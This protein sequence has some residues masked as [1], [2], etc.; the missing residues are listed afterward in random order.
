LKTV[1]GACERCLVKSGAPGTSHQSPVTP[2]KLRRNLNQEPSILRPNR[3]LLAIV[4]LL[5]AP[6]LFAR[7]LGKYKDWDQS[8]QGYFM[9]KPER[10]QWQAVKTED[11]AEKFVNAFLANRPATF[12]QNVADRAAQADKYLTIGKLQGSKTIR[13]KVVILLGPPQGL[14]V[15]TTTKT[16]T[17]RDSP[18]A[19]DAISNV[20]SGVDSGG[21]SEGTT[22]LGSSIGTVSTSRLYHFT[23]S[24]DA[25]K[26]V[27]R[28]K[29]E[30]TVEADPYTGKDRVAGR[31]E[32][33]ELDQVFELAAR[34]SLKK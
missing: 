28:N 15:S 27:D 30:V 32:A 25:A 16:S 2:G 8:P 7:G 9:T 6:T 22:G 17:K 11:D 20:G 23:Y 4:A 18:A 5:I 29:I 3:L 21:K 12:V 19:S 31:D 33:T 13:G 10:D 1:T 14:D 24:G 26:K 34:N